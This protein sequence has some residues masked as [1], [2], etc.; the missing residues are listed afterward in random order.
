MN[1]LRILLLAVLLCALGAAAVRAD[2]P[3][4]QTAKPL[5]PGDLTVWPLH[6]R[7]ANDAPGAARSG[8]MNDFGEFQRFTP[9]DYL[10]T[11]IDIR[12]VWNGATSKG[13]I[14]LVAAPGCSPRARCFRLRTARA[15]SRQPSVRLAPPSC[16]IWSRTRNAA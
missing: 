12:G 15:C 6:V 3:D 1:R 13:D 7:L 11:G 16:K 10:H 8:L 14:V 2:Q 5:K 9:P 4:C